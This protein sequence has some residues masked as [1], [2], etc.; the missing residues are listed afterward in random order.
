[1]RS[2]PPDLEQKADRFSTNHVRRSEVRSRR[3]PLFPPIPYV[4]TSQAPRALGLGEVL[5]R[6][7]EQGHYGQ[8]CGTAQRG[9]RVPTRLDRNSRTWL[10]CAPCA[11]I[12]YHLG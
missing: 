11:P 12:Q 9:C 1:M 7:C 8:I 3:L 5:D 10:C 6:S 4:S 2:H